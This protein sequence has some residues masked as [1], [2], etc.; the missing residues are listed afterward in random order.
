MRRV[1]LPLAVVASCALLCSPRAASSGPFTP[2]RI[3]FA[4]APGSLD[5]LRLFEAPDEWPRARA[6]IDVYK[7]YHQHTFRTPPDIVGPN[8][9]DALVRVD[10]FRKLRRWGKRIALEAGSV[11]EFYCT[12][13]GSGMRESIDLTLDALD[14]VRAAGGAVH[15][16]TMDEPFLAGQ[17]RQCGGPALEPTADRVRQYITEVQ[18]ASPVTRVGLIEPYP[19]FRPEAFASMLRLLSDRGTPAAF[20]HVDAY[21]PALQAGRDEFGSDMIRL[22]DIAG[23]FGIPFGIIIWG[24]NGNADHLYAADAMKLAD[25]VGR[26][27]RSWAVMPP[28]IIFQSW[29]ESSTGLRIAPTNLPETGAN[30]HTRLLNEI[31]RS[32]REGYKGGRR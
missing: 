26:T 29:A 3:W 9:Y 28:Q 25:A 13:D 23:S 32:F 24:E 30:T 14:A 4:P 1:W 5:L 16:I 10:A 2:T 22:A 11:K 19:Y 12:P 15:Y 8:S 6:A 20:L 27:F 31:Y 21:L 17:A 18:S 7:F